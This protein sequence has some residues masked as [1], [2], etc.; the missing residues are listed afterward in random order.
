MMM[1]RSL[2]YTLM[3]FMAAALATAACSR[4]EMG[5][6]KTE[7]DGKVRVAFRLPAYYGD[8][9]FASDE[10]V[11]TKADQLGSLRDLEDIKPGIRAFALPEGS[12][13]WLTYSKQK[14]DGTFTNPDLQAYQVRNAGG[15]NAL[16]PCEIVSTEGK[17]ST[18]KTVTFKNIQESEDSAP[19]YLEPGVYKFK[20][21]SPALQIIQESNDDGTFNWKLP[22]DNGMYFCSTDGR[23]SQT[24]AETTTINA[25][26]T[27]STSGHVQYVTLNPMMQQT[28]KMDFRIVKDVETV[29]SLSILPTGIE[30]S[31]LQNPGLNAHYYWTSENIAD[32]LVMKMGDKRSW[33]KI[34][35][36]DFKTVDGYR[37]NFI[38][39]PDSAEDDGPETYDEALIGD[40]GVL[41][42]DARSTTIIITFNLLVNGIPTQYVTSLNEIILEHGHSY[43]LNLMVS[44]NNG[45]T[46]FTWQYQSWTTDLE[47]EKQM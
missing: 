26:E 38:D 30:I 11:M 44:Q 7:T 17:D 3:V 31:G 2:S 9:G 28:A 8:T 4:D 10:G 16:Y 15:F 32:T 43:V 42:T 36:E 29:D 5:G 20:M 14:G 22:I 1:K 39:R 35:A 21:I 40:I 33:T 46:V 12:T 41:P 37:W 6:G 27:G 18:G 34:L 24:V 47:L 23:Y 45:I 25:P 13:L 19:L